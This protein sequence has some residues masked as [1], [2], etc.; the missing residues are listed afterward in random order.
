[1]MS[2]SGSLSQFLL[3][4]FADTR[5]LQLLHFCLSLGISLATLLGNGL[6]VSAGACDR[7]LHT[8]VFSFLLSLSLTHL[9]SSCTTVPKASG[10]GIF[11]QLSVS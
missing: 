8:P 4:A 11:S 5:E 2:N 9:G 10:Q 7:H 3:L 6:I 1:Q